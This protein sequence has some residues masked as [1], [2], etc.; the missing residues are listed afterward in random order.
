MTDRQG[1]TFDY[2][3]AVRLHLENGLSFAAIGGRMGVTRERIRQVVREAGVTVEQSRNIRAAKMLKRKRRR[4]ARCGEAFIKKQSV[5]QYCSPE[6]G[7]KSTADQKRKYSDAD[8]LAHLR[9]LG[10]RL[11]KT[12][13]TLD[14]NNH[15][16]PCHRTYYYRFGSLR[17]AQQLAG[18]ESNESGKPARALQKEKCG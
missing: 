13:S 11:G 6:C 16:G 18:L 9:D 1:P 17:R 5:Q 3:E 15:T 2:D 10:E 8:L 14:L 12:P 4:C 7:W